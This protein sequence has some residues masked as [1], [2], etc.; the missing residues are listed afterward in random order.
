MMNCK[1]ACSIAPGD[2]TLATINNC[3]SISVFGP[4]HECIGKFGVHGKGKGPINNSGI[5]FIIEY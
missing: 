2:H 3:N 5:V 4:T 1:N